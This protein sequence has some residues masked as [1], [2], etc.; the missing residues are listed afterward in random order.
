LNFDLAEAHDFDGGFEAQDGDMSL[1][2]D[3]IDV[4]GVGKVDRDTCFLSEVRT[5]DGV[6]LLVHPCDNLVPFSILVSVAG[7]DFWESDPH[8]FIGA[9]FRRC[10]CEFP[11]GSELCKSSH[12][13]F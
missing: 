9:R 1:L 4:V 13:Y 2:C 6:A 5:A 11:F 12:P 7:G 8:T 3:F 10:P